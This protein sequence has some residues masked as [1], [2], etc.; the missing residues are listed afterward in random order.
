MG[1]MPKM[2]GDFRL[3]SAKNYQIWDAEIDGVSELGLVIMVRARLC[4]EYRFTLE[5]EFL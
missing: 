5:D 3:P 1:T 4:R 2:G